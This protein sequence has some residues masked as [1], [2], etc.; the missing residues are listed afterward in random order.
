M[1]GD[2]PLTF[3]NLTMKLPKIW[4]EFGQWHLIYLG[5]GFFEFQYAAK[6]EKM[7]VWSIGTY[8][9]TPGFLR[10]SK[11]ELDSNPYT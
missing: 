8:N 3:Q 10:L 4:K 2:K 11:W 7:K 1:I 6:D 9:L 5:Q